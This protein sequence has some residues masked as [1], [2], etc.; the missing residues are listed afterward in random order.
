MQSWSVSVNCSASKTLWQQSLQIFLRS[1]AAQQRWR[2]KIPEGVFLLLNSV[3]ECSVKHRVAG[4][5]QRGVA[6]GR[7]V[8]SGLH[9]PICICTERDAF[10]HGD[11]VGNQCMSMTAVAVKNTHVSNQCMYEHSDSGC[12]V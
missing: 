5:A 12:Q 7:A 10:K 2:Q 8:F 4:A 1:P 3:Y 11:I 9:Q 6:V